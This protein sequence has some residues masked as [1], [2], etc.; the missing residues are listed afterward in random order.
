VIVG[1]H[2]GPVQTDTLFVASH[3]DAEGCFETAP[4]GEGAYVVSVAADGYGRSAGQSIV[5]GTEDEKLE[6]A[7]EPGGTIVGRVLDAKSKS[8]IQGARVSLEQSF[9]SELIAPATVLTD[10]DGGFSLGGLAPGLRSIFAAAKDHHGRIVGGVEVVSGGASLPV[11][12]ELSP[13]EEGDE[14]RI[15]LAGIGA[16]LTAEGDAVIVG[17]VL[18]GG[19]AA[20]AG[21]KP[22]DAIVAVEA[23]PVST[24]GLEGTITNI[25]GPEGT[26]V[27]LS[28]R[29]IG[30]EAPVTLKVERRRIRT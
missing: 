30:Q 9:A 22:G 11:I 5:L 28:V 7:L 26:W 23:M 16:V 24:L 21:M 1:E 2:V 10:A 27:E 18:D 19:G 4:L 12:I 15:E 6:F 29:K 17:R 14:P 20:A 25:R 8:P 3:F 13:V